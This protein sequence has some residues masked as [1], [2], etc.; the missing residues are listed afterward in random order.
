MVLGYTFTYRQLPGQGDVFVGGVIVPTGSEQ[1][2]RLHTPSL[3]VTYVPVPWLVLKPYVSYQT[4]ASQNLVAGNFNA[5]IVGLQ[6][7][8]QWQR[9]V[10]PPR[11]PLN[12]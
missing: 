2:Q 6:F 11:T 8:L 7:T 10:I 5:T 4:R 1:T 9:G 3:A 12:Y